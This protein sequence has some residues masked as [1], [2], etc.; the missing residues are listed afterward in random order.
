MQQYIREKYDRLHHASHRSVYW[1]YL[2]QP[3][4]M[5]TFLGCMHASNTFPF[6]VIGILDTN[7]NLKWTIQIRIIIDYIFYDDIIRLS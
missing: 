3:P 7:F 5:A 4:L 6:Y 1:G 2:N